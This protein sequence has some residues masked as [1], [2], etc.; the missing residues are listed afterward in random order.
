MKNS[1]LMNLCYC[2]RQDKDKGRECESAREREREGKEKELKNGND[3]VIQR[4]TLKRQQVQSHTYVG[5]QV[6]ER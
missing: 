3:N 1:D 6:W 5:R 2:R 4:Q